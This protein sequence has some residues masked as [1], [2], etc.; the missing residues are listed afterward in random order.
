VIAQDASVEDVLVYFIFPLL[1]G[2]IV[3]GILTAMGAIVVV[4]SRHR[5]R[6]VRLRQH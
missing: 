2:L 1:L 6:H 3:L 4:L 5:L